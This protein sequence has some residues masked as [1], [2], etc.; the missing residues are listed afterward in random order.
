MDKGTDAKSM[1][2]NKQVQLKLGYVGI[3]N[4]CQQDIIDKIKVVEALEREAQYFESHPVYSL[5]PP[6]YT[7]TKAL[8]TKLTT[9]MF[10]HIRK[11]LPAIVKEI[12]VK[13]K[14]CEEKLK[15]FGPALPRDP[16]EKMQV[17]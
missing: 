11:F 7:G 1:L 9:V 4:R 15:D 17:I 14:E 3:K 8:T 10:H 13:I 12:A 2:M 6:G 16:E 5:M